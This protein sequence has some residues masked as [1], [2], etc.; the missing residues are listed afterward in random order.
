VRYLAHF[1]DGR[2]LESLG[3]LPEA[4]AAYEAALAIT[5]TAQS[6]R[7]ALA[8][9]KYSQGALDAAPSLVEAVL[10]SPLNADDPWA[11]YH[12][13]GYRNWPERIQVVREALR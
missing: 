7:L 8:A 4:V 3:R 11:L 1:L 2:V 10:T 9:L 6:G 5:P 13:G 12:Y